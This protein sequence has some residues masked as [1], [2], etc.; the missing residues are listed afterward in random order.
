MYTFEK[1]TTTHFQSL[2]IRLDPCNPESKSLGETKFVFR[3]IID[4]R[5]NWVG[6]GGMSSSLLGAAGGR[7]PMTS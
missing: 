1:K 3:S 5:Q 6:K 4:I 2:F 7:L